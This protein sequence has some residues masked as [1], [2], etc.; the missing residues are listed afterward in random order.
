ME[1]YI[2]IS[3]GGGDTGLGQLHAGVQHD[4][5][6]GVPAPLLRLPGPIPPPPQVQGETS[7]AGNG[8]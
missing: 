1:M 3:T 2:E 8:P 4:D 7:R 5:G 6:D